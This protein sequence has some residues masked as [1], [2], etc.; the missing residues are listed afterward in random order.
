MP[1][2]LSS[3]PSLAEASQLIIGTTFGKD[4]RLIYATSMSVHRHLDVEHCM[5]ISQERVLSN[6]LPMIL[7][8]LLHEGRAAT[9]DAVFACASIELVYSAI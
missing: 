4:F 6:L 5:I 3:A 9:A 7:I 2:T 8:S 1:Q